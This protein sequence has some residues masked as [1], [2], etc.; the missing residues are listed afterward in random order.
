MAAFM[1]ESAIDVDA[2]ADS[3]IEGLAEESFLI[4]PHP[5]VAQYI[6]NKAGDYDRFNWGAASSGP[7]TDDLDQSASRRHRTGPAG[8]PGD[9]RPTVGRR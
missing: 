8:V 7:I 2:V 5:E 6:L 3:V 1:D 4:L 9:D